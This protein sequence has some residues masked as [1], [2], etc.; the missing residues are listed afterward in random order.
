MAITVKNHTIPNI[1]ISTIMGHSGG[2]M[3]PFTLSPAY[4]RLR[5]VIWETKTVNLAKSST[6]EKNLGNFRLFNPFTWKYIQRLEGE[7]LL[8]AYGLTND[9]VEANAVAIALA[10]DTGFK[11]IPNFY[12]QFSKGRKLAIEETVRAISIYTIKLG[13]YFW[14]LELNFSCPNSKEKIKEN[15][16]DALACVE[17]VRWD[18]PELCLIAKIS[19]VHPYEFAEELV[20]AGVDIIHAIN[21]I[22]YEL[23]NPPYGKPSPLQ[24]VGGGG[25]SGKPA[26][27]Q[28]FGY[29]HDLRKKISVPII[30]GCGVTRL[31]DAKSFF[32]IGADAVS[33][34]TVCRLD[35]R[36]AERIIEEYAN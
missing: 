20:M 3:F 5:Q 16:Q 4:R 19:I 15:I 10:Q 18:F 17:A 2:G 12:P 9:G 21:T 23:M 29:N 6:C 34:C 22:P 32:N 8:N 36:E 27:P 7:G 24:A 28:A 1:A 25:V 30:M 14:V 26:F 35:P 13:R 31:S 11:V 33:L